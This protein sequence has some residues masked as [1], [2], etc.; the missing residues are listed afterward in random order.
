LGSIVDVYVNPLDPADS[1]LEPGISERARSHQLGMV[2][3]GVVIV[4]CSFAIEWF[5][6]FWT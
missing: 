3:G 6:L 2:A 5:L 4:A 1:V